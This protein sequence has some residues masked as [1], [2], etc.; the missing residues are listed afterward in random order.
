MWAPTCGHRIGVQQVSVK[1]ILPPL[2][3]ILESVCLPSEHSPSLCAQTSDGSTR[4]A[5]MRKGSVYVDPDRIHC[6]LLQAGNVILRPC[7]RVKSY[8]LDHIITSTAEDSLKRIL[9]ENIGEIENWMSKRE[10]RQILRER[11]NFYCGNASALLILRTFGTYGSSRSI[12][13]PSVS[14]LP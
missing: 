13:T 11:R 3:P 2:Q 4:E 10:V 7:P 14:S 9:T 5:S 12:D 1:S 6:V 8:S